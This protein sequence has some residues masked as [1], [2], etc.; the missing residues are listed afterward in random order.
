MEC[1]VGVGIVTTAGR[2]DYLDKTVKSLLKS[3]PEGVGVTIF[4]DL[5]KGLTPNHI[6]SWK[7]LYKDPTTS[8]GL[9]IQDD[10]L[11]S[12][13]W[14]EAACLL[15]EKFP[16]VSLYSGLGVTQD[17]K[18]FVEIPAHKWINEQALMI[19]KDVL[20]MYL[21][22]VMGDGH[23]KVLPESELKHHDSILRAFFKEFGIKIVLSSP[24]IFQ[25]IGVD[26]TMG[27][28]FTI[29][30]NKRESKSFEGEDF[31]AYEFMKE[32]LNA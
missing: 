27:H 31:D 17:R 11:A 22:W 26:S 4:K 6:A 8:H 14:Y 16:V 24:S 9:L 23:K 13:N 2:E 32:R 20:A 25:H 3:Y 12:K 1:K 19:R 5:E 18:G 10:T 7:E 29:G 15:A 30:R 21:G 28:P